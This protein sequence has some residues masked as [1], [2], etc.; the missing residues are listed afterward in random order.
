MQKNI[1]LQRD[2]TMEMVSVVYLFSLSAA[3]N[4]VV[5]EIHLAKQ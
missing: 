2:E 5:N 3:I 1:S 4:R